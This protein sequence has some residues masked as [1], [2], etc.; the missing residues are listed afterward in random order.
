MYIGVAVLL[1]ILCGVAY[2]M[3]SKKIP[4]VL[5]APIPG[6]WYD[7]NSVWGKANTPPYSS[8]TVAN[9]DCITSCNADPKCMTMA[10]IN[11]SATKPKNTCNYFGT[12]IPTTQITHGA[13]W[14]GQI[15]YKAAPTTSA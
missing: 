13:G 12:V 1:I 8:T 2:Y 5:G 15:A 10:M 14:P 7:G 11:T 3:Y 6:G 9:A 4:M